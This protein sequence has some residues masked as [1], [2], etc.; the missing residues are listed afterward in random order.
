M[1]VLRGSALERIWPRL[2]LT[3]AVAVV[4]TVIDLYVGK[5]HGN[6]T[7]IPFSLIGLALSIFLGFRN[8]TSYDRFWEGRKL[9]GGLVNSSRTIT[10]QV[11]TL[12][13]D[14]D[15]ATRDELVKR[16][17]AYVHLLRLHL[18]DDPD[19]S[20]LRSLLPADEFAALDREWNRPVYLLQRLGER[21]RELY[22]D[23]RIHALHLAQ[24]DNTLTDM[25][26]LQGACERIKSTPIPFTYN[27]LIHRI[28]AIYCFTLPFGLIHAIGGYTP[29]VVALIS[30]AF[31]GLDA[32][33][34][35]IE[36]PFGL[37]PNDLPLGALSTLIER[38]LRQR[39]GETE[40][41]PMPEGRFLT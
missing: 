38:N 6:L 14:V 41:P 28:V 23:G 36:D 3:V 5:F 19:H 1:F 27:V 12:I 32:V 20:E 7:P 15:D 8:N 37:D 4:V 39:M 18:R 25:T 34:E 9:W 26:N 30:Y 35:Q 33:G 40:L 16:V 22:D 24:L 11:T 13:S 10:R 21:F 29:V 2:L 31:F 17:I